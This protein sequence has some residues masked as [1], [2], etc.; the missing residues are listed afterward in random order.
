M[1]N[2]LSVGTL[3]DLH[4]IFVHQG[5][6]I[7]NDF[8]FNRFCEMLSFLNTDQQEC[9]LELTKKFLRVDLSQYHFH[10]KKALQKIT[11]KDLS[12]IETLFVSPLLTNEDRNKNTKSSRFLAYILAGREIRA[13]DILH[14]NTV[15]VLVKNEWLHPILKANNWKLLLVDDFIG[16]GETAETALNELIQETGISLN[17]IIVLA[18]VSQNAGYQRLVSH[19]VTVVYSEM[20]K[21]GISDEFVDPTRQQFLSI[22]KSI[23]DMLRVKPINRFGYKGSEALVTLERTPNNTFPVYWD[24]SNVEGEKFISPFPRYD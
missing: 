15:K 11:V 9:I 16:T 3:Q 21:K 18:L 22:M 23:E 10:I 4:N 14:V 2:N 24:A 5:W 19:G 20:R 13:K 8:V 1:K 7:Q 12:N 6:E 17:R